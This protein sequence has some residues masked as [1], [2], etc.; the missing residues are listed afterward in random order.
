MPNEEMPEQVL[1]LDPL[2]TAMNHLMISRNST[3][4]ALQNLKAQLED[5]IL[6]EAERQ[7]DLR[8]LIAHLANLP[9]TEQK[10]V[11]ESRSRSKKTANLSPG[12]I[13]TEPS[14]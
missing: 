14:V 13:G 6:R 5:L 9:K 12:E 10:S 3:L 11:G 8:Y 1:S 7:V 2:G 4:P